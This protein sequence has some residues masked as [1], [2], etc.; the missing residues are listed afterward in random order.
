MLES[1]DAWLRY[2]R[3][4]STI[5]LY[6]QTLYTR[7]KRPQR[8]KFRREHILLSTP[9]PATMLAQ[10]HVNFPCFRESE[11]TSRSHYFFIYFIS[12]CK[13]TGL[14]IPITLTDW[15]DATTGTLLPIR[16]V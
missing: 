16:R 2:D 11:N 7:H 10:H 3:T 15:T 12:I 6:I 9:R 5:I 14:H 13:Q 1:R 4:Y 8:V